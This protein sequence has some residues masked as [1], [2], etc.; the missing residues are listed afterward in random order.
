[1]KKRP[2]LPQ[3]YLWGQMIL[4]GLGVL[5]LGLAIAYIGFFLSQK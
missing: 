1:M 4:I 5:S 2:M 3:D